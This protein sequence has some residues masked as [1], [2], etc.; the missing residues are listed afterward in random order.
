MTT[1]ERL[2]DDAHRTLF[3]VSAIGEGSTGDERQIERVRSS[4]G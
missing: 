2:V 3:A 1:N 4:W